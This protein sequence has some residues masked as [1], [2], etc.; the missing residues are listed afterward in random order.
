[1]EQDDELV[2]PHSRHGVG[3]AG[4]V[5]Q[6]ARHGL[7]EGVSGLVAGRVVHGLEGVE[8]EVESQKAE[9]LPGAPAAGELVPEAVEEEGPVGKL[10]QRVVESW[11]WTRPASTAIPSVPPSAR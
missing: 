8:V 2:S 6:A 3:L 7:E 9:A 4:A 1:M 11:A 5:P 10:G